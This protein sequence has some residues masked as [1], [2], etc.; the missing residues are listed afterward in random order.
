VI[1]L[2]IDTAGQSGSVAL[3]DE[4]QI[5]ASFY[6]RQAPTFSSH[7]VRLVDVVCSQMGYGVDDLGGFAVSLG[8][9]GFTSLRVALATAQGLAMATGKPLVGCSTF[10]ALVALAAGWDGSI[11]P[12]LEA[13]R[14]EVYAAFYSRQGA[15]I[16]ETM[17][18]MVTTPDTLCTLVTKCTLFVGSGVRTYGRLF[19][20]TL[21][22][23]AVC[24][25]SAIEGELAASV[26]CLGQT[27]LHD[28]SPAR[29]D[30]LKPLYIRAADARL[31]RHPVAIAA[32]DLP[33]GPTAPG[34]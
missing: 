13:R 25:E 11:C 18:G 20:A 29:R 14:G 4:T 24:L 23:R 28:A 2:G 7:L 31:P 21:G 26:A 3:V 10:E 5:L 17:P 1:I 22:A 15:T 34:A 27:R 8:P 9:G 19:A 12:V 30:A 33:R 16:R 32:H 6:L